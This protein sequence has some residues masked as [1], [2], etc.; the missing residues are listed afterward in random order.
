MMSD[1]LTFLVECG[2]YPCVF[3]KMRYPIYDWQVWS[4][5]EFSQD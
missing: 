1:F 3:G 2:I 5:S 4:K